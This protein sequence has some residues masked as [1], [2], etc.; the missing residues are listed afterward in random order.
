M[1]CHETQRLLSLAQDVPL[2]DQQRDALSR[3][4]ADCPACRQHQSALAQASSVFRQDATAVAI[5]DIEQEISAVQA[6]LS[7][8]APQRKRTLAPILWLSAPL[9]AAAIMLAFLSGIQI[10]FTTPDAPTTHVDYVVAG[11][12]SASTVVYV[13]QDSGWLV[14]WASSSSL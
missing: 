8:P 10:P 11:D 9:A 6:R 12:P 4:L 5:P 13:D 2:S 7:T 1:S 14:V 3:H